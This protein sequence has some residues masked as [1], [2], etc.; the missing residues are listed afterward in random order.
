MLKKFFFTIGVFISF[1]VFAVEKTSSASKTKQ[2]IKEVNSKSKKN[3]KAK[4]SSP[5]SKKSNIVKFNIKK[6][7]VTETKKISPVLKKSNT[8]RKN[9]QA[10]DKSNTTK[11]Q[12]QAPV[13][14]IL[15]QHRELTNVLKKYLTSDNFVRYW[16]LKCDLR[17]DGEVFK[18]QQH[19]F[20]RYI[21]FIKETTKKEFDSWNKKQQT[22]YLINAYNVLTIEWIIKNYPVES[23]KDTGSIFSSA[24]SKKIFSILGGSI[25]TLD[26]IE[27]DVL[28]KKYKDFRLHAVLNCASYSCPILRSEAYVATKLDKQLDEQMRLWLKDSRR[29]KID[30]KENKV[31]LSKVFSWF[32]EDFKLVGLSER[33]SLLKIIKNYGFP[34]VNDK[35]KITYLSYDWSLNDATNKKQKGKKCIISTR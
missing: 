15:H 12:K 28:R 31:F 27:H 26:T 30:Y 14:D 29:N 4:K 2:I 24:W 23:I 6:K 34:L 16:Q 20:V 7:S 3:I 13:E 22:A 19:D 10:N 8:L 1:G 25:K 18:N 9:I 33:K 21:N 5:R 32:D 17:Y 35:T 11:I